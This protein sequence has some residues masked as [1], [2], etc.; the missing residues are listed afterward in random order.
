MICFHQALALRPWH[1]PGSFQ[2]T[3][4]SGIPNEPRSSRTIHLDPGTFGLMSGEAINI[5]EVLQETTQFLPF[6][7]SQAWKGEGGIQSGKS[8]DTF[9]KIWR[10]PV[11]MKYQ[12]SL[13]EQSIERRKNPRDRRVKTRLPS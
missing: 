12:G 5:R 11:N 10:A 8:V 7:H 1:K 2:I 6:F 3:H 4:A 13:A 9:P